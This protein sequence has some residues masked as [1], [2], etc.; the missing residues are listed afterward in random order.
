M[1][2]KNATLYL[3]EIV[4]LLL[5]MFILLRARDSAI[6]KWRIPICVIKNAILPCLSSL[7]GTD[8]AGCSHIL[9]LRTLPRPMTAAA[10]RN[11][12]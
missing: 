6:G 4:G 3:G 5:Y 1:H 9:Y 7:S 10:V 8:W 12:S 11:K 2:R